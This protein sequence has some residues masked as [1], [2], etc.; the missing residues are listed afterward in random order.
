MA[1]FAIDGRFILRQQRGM[2]T[3]VTTVCKLLPKSMPEHIFYILINT[4]FEHNCEKAEYDQRIKS[5]DKC[6]NVIFVDL[7]ADDEYSWELFKLPQWLKNNRVDLLHMPTNRTCILSSTKQIMTLHDAMEWEFNKQN[8]SAPKDANFKIKLYTFKKKLYVFLNYFY[9][10]RK[11]KRVV[12]ISNSAKYSIIKNFPFTQGKVDVIYHGIPE[13]YSPAIEDSNF[14]Q[15]KNILMLGGESYQKNP[16]NMLKGYAKLSEMQ[17]SQ[18]HLTIVGKKLD[19]N[20]IID[21]LIEELNL[22]KFVKIYNWID[23][24]KLIKLF[25]TS[26]AL[27]FVSRQEGFGF[28][29]LQAMA[30]GTPAVISKAEVLSEISKNAALEADAENP[31]QI[32]SQ[33]E[34]LIENEDVWQE[35]NAIGKTVANSFTWDQSINALKKVY[36][37]AIK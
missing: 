37:E 13:Y 4:D 19:S 5:I 12:T 18:N 6:D 3:Y 17:K 31:N 10:M 22:Q 30:C 2:P 16:E 28:P 9:G 15:R 1:N 33:L 36:M 14:N 8:H 26:K 11:V 29:L 20:S 34:Q 27:L 32:H 23:E 21:N 24:E 25:Q 35:K 7:Q